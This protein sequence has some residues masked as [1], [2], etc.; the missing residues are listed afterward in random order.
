[1][2]MGW[3]LMAGDF[4]LLLVAALI[5]IALTGLP[6]FIP[7]INYLAPVI[8]IFLWPPLMAGLFW[9]VLRRA[10]GGSTQIES[11]FAGFSGRYWDCVLV[12]I[13]ITLTGLVASILAFVAGLGAQAGMARIQPA[14]QGGEEWKAIVS[15]MLPYMAVLLGVELGRQILI[16]AAGFL[17]MFALLGV[18]EYPARPWEAVKASFRLVCWRFWEALGFSV[19]FAMLWFGAWTVGTLA[20]CVGRLFTL[21]VFQIWHAGAIVYL[22][23]SW[24]GRPLVQPRRA[25]GGPVTEGGPIPPT[26]IQP[27]A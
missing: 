18:W 16:A 5:V 22:Y 11:V 17:L 3:R 14:L 15:V 9:T 26:D 13:P 23:Y 2:G 25:G 8:S 20:C 27:P 19:L 7:C 10:Q 21:S 1:M 4:G 24:T 12:G 6:Y